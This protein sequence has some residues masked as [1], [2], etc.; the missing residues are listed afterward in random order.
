MTIHD[1]LAAAGLSAGDEIPIWQVNSSGEPTRKITAQQLAAAVATIASLVTGVKGNAESTYRT[2]NVN[3][4]PANIGALP[5]STTYVSGVKGNSESS[6]RSGQVNL[7]PANVGAVALSGGIVTGAIFRQVNA[8]FNNPPSSEEWNGIIPY[9]DS[10]NDV[11]GGVYNQREPDGS[12]RTLLGARGS[13]GWGYIAATIDSSG[14]QG[15]IVSHPQAMLSAL[16]I[17]WTKVTGTTGS[18][19]VVGLGLARNRYMVF[20]VWSSVSSGAS[21]IATPMVTANGTNW[22]ALI[23]TISHTAVANT[24]VT[25]YVGYIDFGAGNIS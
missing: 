8:D 10:G 13:N 23:E 5:A 18:T 24:A 9:T 6:Y 3:L 15:Y 14:N 17:R 12:Y 19:G 22:S 4:T 25:L 20:S 16:N 21:Q 7:T 2:G 11:K 1:L